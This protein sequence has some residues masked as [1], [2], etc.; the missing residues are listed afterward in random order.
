VRWLEP[1][2]YRVSPLHLAL[3][4]LSVLFAMLAA[5]RR[6]LYRTGLIPAARL[7]V[8]VIIVGNISAGGTGKTPCVIWLA[9]WLLA[10]GCKPGIVI[11]GYGGTARNPQR[12]APDGDPRVV[13]DEAVLLARR[14]ACP[15]WVGSRRAAT[16][17]ALLAAHPECDMI[18]SDDGLQHYALARDVELAVIDGER[19]CGNGMLLPAGPLREPTGRLARVDA[20]VING[21][22][23]FP[24]E[25]LPS[26]VP[27]FDMRL[28]GNTF[29]DLRNPERGVGPG[30][31]AT[32]TVHAI[33]A[34][35]NPQRFFQTLHELGVSFSAHPFPDHHA[36]TSADCAFGA[37]A[38]VI[39]TEKDA[40]KCERFGGDNWW[41]LR[42]DTTLEPALGDL[43]LHKI[44]NESP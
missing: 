33:A 7:R 38:A 18:I 20:I 29:Y 10:H 39:M 5:A 41:A 13:G 31:F 14:S 23:V 22:A 40:V 21:G 1:Y 44:G 32:Q 26:G 35:G 4:P 30:H 25:I 37:N 24:P 19:G 17:E 8:P 2:W 11:R 34:I 12:A 43:I 3:W 6:L 42:V 28:D 16:A 15:V 9:Q 27:V 36:Y